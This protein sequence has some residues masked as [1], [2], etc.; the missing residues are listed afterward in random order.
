MRWSRIKN[1]T[2][3]R[4]SRLL[5]LGIVLDRKKTTWLVQCDCGSI[6][7]V[8][9]SGLLVGDTQSCGCLKRERISQ[10][11]RTHGE[12]AN[13][14]RYTPEYTAYKAAA[15]RCTN[16]NNPKFSYYGGRGIEFRF[17][18][19]EQFIE[20]LGR[21]PSPLHS[22]DRKNNEGHYEPGNVRW[23]TKKEQANNRR[24]AQR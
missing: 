22:V 19:L 20:V 15:G 4:F 8:T 3:K 5:V 13:S 10:A 21:R 24:P 14:K 12:T 2:G 7:E 16:P 9:S 11:K 1:L 17:E 23:A 18:S 6:N